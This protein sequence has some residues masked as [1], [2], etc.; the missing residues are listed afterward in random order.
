MPS[1]DYL[2]DLKGKLEED[3]L[4]YF[5]VV[6]SR[7]EVKNNANVSY[8]LSKK[9][10]IETLKRVLHRLDIEGAMEECDD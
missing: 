10:T 7:G 3:N 9:H 1:L 2:E 8:K 4:D 6:I 5:M